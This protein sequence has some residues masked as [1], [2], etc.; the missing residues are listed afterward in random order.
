[1]G[2]DDATL[3]EWERLTR[4]DLCDNRP[5]ERLESAL[6][7]AITEIRRL[8]EESSRHWASVTDRWSSTNDKFQQERIKWDNQYE[9]LQSTLAAHRAVMRELA[10]A[11]HGLYTLVE[12]GLLVR[13]ITNDSHFP[14]YMAE[15]T[16]VVMALKKT[17]D[18]LA[19]PLV[20]AARREGGDE[21]S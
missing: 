7:E 16:E 5:C 19:H 10:E 1:M 20:V 3:A 17:T 9:A 4:S 12:K 11:L 8:R 2:I 21:D 6:Q 18:A 15:A 13:N 14:S